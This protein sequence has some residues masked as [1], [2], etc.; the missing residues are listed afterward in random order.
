MTEITHLKSTAGPRYPFDNEISV[1][2]TISNPQLELVLT[3]VAHLA[4]YRSN[5]IQ[6]FKMYLHTHAIDSTEEL[7]WGLRIVT[8][9]PNT[10][11][12]HPH[13]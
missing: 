1:P 11:S 7:R 10:K 9:W 6:G 2:V 12:D 4:I 5:T 13:I 8:K 3:G